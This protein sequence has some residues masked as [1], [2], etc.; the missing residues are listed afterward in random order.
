MMLVTG[1]G[2][3]SKTRFAI[4]V[5]LP[6]EKLRSVGAEEK[7]KR[8]GPKKGSLIAMDRID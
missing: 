6:R 4:I 5:Y 2:A 1:K 8:H 3:K 7:G